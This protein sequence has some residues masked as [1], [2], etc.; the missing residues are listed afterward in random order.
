LLAVAMAT[1][2]SGWAAAWTQAWGKVLAT[3]SIT[4]FGF[5]VW[6]DPQTANNINNCPKYLEAAVLAQ[7]AAEFFMTYSNGVPSESQKV[8]ITQ[9]SLAVSTG[10]LVKIYS[11][12]CNNYGNYN[13]LDGVSLKPN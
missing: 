4:G 10:Q 8:T 3:A 6:I 9:L 13:S 2:V 12:S 5:Y 7:P 1:P 11:G